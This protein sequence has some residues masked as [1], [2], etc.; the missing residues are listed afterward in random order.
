[1]QEGT[2]N[3]IK[4]V[5][6]I[7]KNIKLLDQGTDHSLFRFRSSGR[8][9]LRRK[10][11][12]KEKDFV[13]IYTGKV[14]T[15]KG[16]HILFEAFSIL[17]RKYDSIYL[18]IV[19]SGQKDYQKMCLSYLTKDL[20]KRVFWIKFQPSK[21]LPDYYS[22]SDLAVWPLQESLSMNDAAACERVFIANDELTSKTRISNNN[23]LLYKK[24]DVKDLARKI[25]FMYKNPKKRIA[26]GKRGRKL[27]EEKLSWEKIAEGY[28]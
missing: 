21:K 1:M 15:A 25:E 11:K 20:N 8:S 3:M 7:N 23:A 18:A 26:M 27:V 16:V 14:I 13:I 12:L 2:V 24:S 9:S 22:F 6:G 4:N 17:A 10:Y 5:Y 28:L 19:G